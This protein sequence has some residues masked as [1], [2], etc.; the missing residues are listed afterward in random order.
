MVPLTGT[1]IH[2]DVC[3]TKGARLLL[4]LLLLRHLQFRD[5]RTDP[6]LSLSL[7]VGCLLHALGKG[8]KG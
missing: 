4:L 5:N 7:P 1:A 8:W 6:I 2:V 3:T